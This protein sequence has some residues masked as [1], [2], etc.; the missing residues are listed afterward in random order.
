[1]KIITT[2]V[3]AGGPMG[4]LGGFLSRTAGR[5]DVTARCDARLSSAVPVDA[6]A[7]PLHRS[8]VL[9]RSG[10]PSESATLRTSFLAGA[11]SILSVAWAIS[12]CGQILGVDEYHVAQKAPEN[13]GNTVCGLSYGTNA[14]AACARTTCCDEATACA[15][16][17]ACNAYETCLGACP[18]GDAACRARCG[19]DHP[20]GTA[21]EVSAL[22]ACLVT[23]C[24][25]DCGLT[26]GALAG[27]AVEPDAAAAFQTCMA[28]N[29]CDPVRACASSVD[30]DAA[31]RCFAACPTND[32]IDT[33]MASRGADPAWWFPDATVSDAT[34]TFVGFA[35]ARTACAAD[36]G[37]YWECVGHVSWPSVQVAN[38][39]IQTV[40]VDASNKTAHS[41]I[42]V[43]ACGQ[44]DL[45]CTPP[46]AAGQTDSAGRVSLDVPAL[47]AGYLKLISPTTVDSY[48]YWGF[49]LTHARYVFGPGRSG[50]AKSGISIFTT[51]ALA[52]L[53]QPIAAVDAG[54]ADPNRGT[55]AVVVEDCLAAVAAGVEVTL[56]T[57]DSKT[58]AFSVGGSPTVPVT[59]SSGALVFIN[60]PLGPLT[61]TAIPRVLGKPSG[62]VDASARLGFTLVNLRPT[63]L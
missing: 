35:R 39:T 1:V 19:I 60:V 46:W 4:I 36:A 33:C 20:S 45:A 21:A 54:T 5:A 32:C 9:E 43:E 59:D 25:T 44:L 53:G 47:G 49:P 40:V 34:S 18:R 56:S 27:W 2:A 58:I 6:R 12:G 24:E 11:T 28:S 8:T 26:C 57:A 38:T 42:D 50:A 52:M 63:P 17:A 7:H 31:T 55:V 61:V 14:C 15:A 30:C 37:G 62:K 51:D 41:G 3:L 10:P 48:N 13:T 29:S 22:S 23:H 16:N